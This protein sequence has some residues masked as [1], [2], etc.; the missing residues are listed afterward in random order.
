MKGSTLRPGVGDIVAGRFTLL[1]L[2]GTGGMGVVYRAADALRAQ[3]VALKMLRPEAAP[4][5]TTRFL[6]E[7]QLLSELRHPGIVQYVDHGQTTESGPYLAMALL[8]GED[9]AARLSRAGLTARETF[10]LIHRVA[11][12]LSVAHRRGIVHRED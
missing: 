7:A 12:A 1:G 2:I 6:H 5:I 8:A 3:T 11:E 4:G 9:L 10:A